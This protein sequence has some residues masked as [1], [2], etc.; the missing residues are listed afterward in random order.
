MNKVD[1]RH[2][3][4]VVSNTRI[5]KDHYRIVLQEDRLPSVTL[6]GQFINI[7]I[8]KRED[9]ILRRPFSV[10]LVRPEKSLFEIVYR[11]VGKGTSAMTILQ[12]DDEV[13]LLGPLGKGFSIPEKAANCFLLGGGCGVAPL[14]GVADKLYRMNSKMTVML[15]F[16]SSATVF[17]EDLF[18]AYDADTFIT[19][20][21][22][23]YGLKGLVSEHLE[24]AMDRQI[25]RAY[26]CG[27]KPMIKAVTPILKRADVE[28]EISL[29]AY[30]GCGFGVCL[31]CVVSVRNGEAIEKQR[32]CTEGP[33]FRLEDIAA[34]HET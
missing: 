8:P 2:S 24:K 23:S 17:G 3:A 34:D 33:V 32:V 14:W 27:P 26:V 10:A 12:P 28:C 4:L 1:L 29:E 20:D 6:P 11:A 31:S 21:D 22:G 30:M 9:L 5:C 13:D 7:R 18:R 16:E 19:T 25:E 15:G